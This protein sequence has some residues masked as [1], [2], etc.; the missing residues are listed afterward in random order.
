MQ[1]LI[2]TGLYLEQVML[3]VMG[4]F[5]EEV[6]FFVIIICSMGSI[7]TTQ[8]LPGK[9]SKFIFVKRFL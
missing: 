4:M 3:L 1:V 7:L 5:L 2:G 8:T 9:I 6:L